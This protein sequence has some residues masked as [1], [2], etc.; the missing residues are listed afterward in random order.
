MRTP[1][2]ALRYSLAVMLPTLL[3][4][5]SLPPRHQRWSPP[6]QLEIT[7]SKCA[8]MSTPSQAC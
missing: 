2:A 1:T 5:T 6:P 8:M 7:V 4:L 3:L